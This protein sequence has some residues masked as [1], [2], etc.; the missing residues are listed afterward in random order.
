VGDFNSAGYSNP[1]LDALIARIRV[2]T[3][4]AR[5]GDLLR[6]AL[7]L[8]KN[9]FAFIPLHQQNVIWAARSNV[10]LVQRADN[11]FA[12]RYVRLK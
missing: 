7:L 3:D 5:R 8:L 4:R 6:Q 9:D 2:E 11:S 12:L 1:A 10:E